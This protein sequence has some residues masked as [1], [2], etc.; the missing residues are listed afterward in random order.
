MIELVIL[1]P[2]LMTQPSPMMD[3][4]T[5][6]ST[7]CRSHVACACQTHVAGVCV[8]NTR[9]PESCRDPL[10]RQGGCLL[11]VHGVPSGVARRPR[12]CWL[13]ERGPT[14]DGGRKRDIV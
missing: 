4:L 10:Q 1:E 7:I 5:S 14:L 12:C 13:P 6:A 3:M 2:D 8:P 9:G 11:Q